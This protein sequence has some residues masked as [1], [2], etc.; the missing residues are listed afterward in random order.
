MYSMNTESLVC[1]DCKKPFSC[2]L[3][4][5]QTYGF[6]C[7]DCKR[8]YTRENL[9]KFRRNNPE[10]IAAYKA[11]WKSR[12]DSAQWIR[13]WTNDAAQRARTWI[14]TLKA[15]PCK[16]CGNTYH[17]SVMEFDHTGADKTACVGHLKRASKAR[18]LAEIAKCELVCANCHR[19]R[20]HM[21]R[22]QKKHNGRLAV[23]SP[24]S[25]VGG[26]Q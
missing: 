2:D 21:R 12:P 19:L 6:W 11:D 22:E 3:K 4:H 17:P 13:K 9:A 25:P 8:R 18:I 10:K 15:S 23:Q 5:R 24:R 14:D 7:P 20:T 1:R 16:D 26:I